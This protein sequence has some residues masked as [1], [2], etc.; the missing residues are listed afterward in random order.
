[1]PFKSLFL[2]YLDAKSFYNTVPHFSVAILD[3][4]I[5]WKWTE[6]TENLWAKWWEMYK[7]MVRESI[8]Y[9]VTGR[10]FGSLNFGVFFGAGLCLSLLQ[11]SITEFQDFIQNIC[12]DHN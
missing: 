4:N 2:R 1:M 9:L 8:Y 10:N 12:V 7:Q 3:L 11:K 6:H 5:N